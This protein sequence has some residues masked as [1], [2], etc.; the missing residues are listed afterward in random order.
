MNDNPKIAYWKKVLSLLNKGQNVFIA[1]V[2]DHTIHS[3]GTPG[4]KLLVTEN[5]EM[6]LI[7]IIQLRES[8]NNIHIV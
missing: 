6:T 1:M 2:V 5:K 8:F 3:P 4:A 7:Y